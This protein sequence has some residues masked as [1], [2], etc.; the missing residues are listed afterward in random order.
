MKDQNK[1]FFRKYKFFII[2]AVVLILICAI[3]GIVL[4][5]Y[6]SRSSDNNHEASV[7]NFTIDHK[8]DTFLMDGKPFRYVA[9][10]FHYFRALPQ[11]WRERLR[12]MKAGGL[13]AVD[14][15][16]HWA[17]HN[18]EDGVYNWEGI[19]DV[20]RIIEIATEENF[21]IILRPGPYIC[22]EID[23]GGLPYWLAT[24]YPGIK[25]RTSDKNYLFEVERWYSKLMPKFVK[26]FYGNGGNIIMVQVENEYGAYSACDNE[27]K[28]FLRDETLKYTQGNA[29]LFTVDWPYDEE[30]QCGS[31]KDVFITVD[32]GRSSF[33]EVIE[34]FAKLREYQPT[35]PLVNTEF[36]SGWFTL[37]QGSHSVTNTSELAKTL[38][39]MLVLGAN[40]DFYV[41]FGGTNF[42]F[43]SGA[44]GR[45]IGN[46]MPDIT[47]YD[48]DAPMDEAGNPT[49]KVYAFK[50]VI[51]K[52][53]SLDDLEIPEKIKTM[54]PGSLTM[55][56]V[57]SLLSA[58]G[59]NILGSRPIE[60]N[61]LL[62]FEQ[63]KQFSGFVLYETELPKLTR[64]PAN[65]FITDL[66]DRAL[67]YVDEEYVGLL[68]RENVINTL[69]INA[70]YGS[71]LSILVENQGRLNFGVTD[72]Y[73][74]IRG[75]VAVQTFDASS[76]NLYEFNNW[77][78]T[79]FPFDKSVDLESLA[80]ASNDYQIDSS[81]LASNGPI[82]FHATLTIND[83]EEIFDT[84]WDTSDWN[85]GF[86]FVNGFNLGRYWSVGPQIT[87]YIPKDILQHGKNAIFLV[88]LQQA[89]NDLKM[90][91]VKGP[92]FINDTPA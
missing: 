25:L 29:V 7:R 78:I 68:S 12:T 19:A 43:W 22:A 69:P 58:E 45:G 51:Q 21:Y 56:P 10:A 55:T 3:V 82:I 66:R 4:G 28:E 14:L 35:G 88:E 70:D 74:G 57:N 73:K 26:H 62:T 32:F 47:S 80:R 39:H 61:T 84:Y 8:H 77:T 40:V 52:Y 44:D 15:Y 90:H 48:Y 24:K 89:S 33:N 34:K 76:N 37:W 6:F 79:G 11:V 65:L 60:S 72:D 31:V 27:Y 30:I 91:F 85:K 42:G 59:R 41:Y 53:L 2:A 86:L 38:D 67:V 83:N 92:I 87:L 46:Y 17:L 64:D 81:G 49:E 16:V 75:T 54:A 71:K 36:Y 23:N 9:G 50:E 13:N 63:L 18:P 5:I 1:T 20:E